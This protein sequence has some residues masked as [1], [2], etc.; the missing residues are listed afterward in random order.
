MLIGIMQGRLLPKVNGKFQ[1]FPG[2]NWKE[3]FNIAAKIGIDL[4]EFIF[5]EDG[6]NINNNPLLNERGLRDIIEISY[7]SGVNVRSVCADYFMKYPFYDPNNFGNIK[8]MKTLIKNLNQ[9]HV[10]EMVLPL[11]DESKL[12][13]NIK[14]I[15]LIKN[16]NEIKQT[17]ADFNLTICL[18]TDLTYSE[19]KELI[20]ELDTEYIK[21]NYDTGNSASLGFN[22]FDELKNNS[23]I[24]SSYHI[25]DRKFN[26][27]SVV[28]GTGDYNFE[29]FFNLIKNKIISPEYL[30]MQTFRDD[31]G[32]KI[33]KKQF[34]WF[35][36]KIK[37]LD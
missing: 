13:T 10:F 15:N 8:L 3:E 17:L 1:A 37:D 18:E 22:T 14:R 23:N 7:S 32:K 33:F 27:G 34:E 29:I 24:I 6:D 16:L 12:D 26:Q 30:I 2:V 20:N 11:V 5:D 25:K 4:I 36:D 28:L 35:K 19:N 9:I 31:E 21:L